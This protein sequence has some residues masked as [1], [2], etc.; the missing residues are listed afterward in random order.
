MK[1][2][3]KIIEFKQIPHTY[4]DLVKILPPR[5]IHDEVDLSNTLEIIDLL[6]GQD[7]NKDQED[8][9]DALSTFVEIY[10]HKHFHI[11]VSHITPLKTLKFFLEEHGMNA[12]DLGRLLGSRTLGS[13][14]LRE[15][16]KL[17]KAHIKILSEYFKV[18][19]GMFLD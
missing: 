17:S 11:N 9:L 2:G 6:A 8:Y 14:I 16:R 12:S 19:P 3:E 4:T 15:R 10:E 1:T 5:P 18:Q 13:A 7:L